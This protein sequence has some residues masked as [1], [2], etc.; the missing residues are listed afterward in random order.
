M[1]DLPPSR[2]YVQTEESRFRSAVSESLAQKIGSSINF[3]NSNQKY[4]KIFVV[5]GQY[6][7]LSLP[8][9]GIDGI[10][11]LPDNAEITNAE[12][13]IRIAGSG[14]DTILDI[15]YATTPGG[16]WTSIFSTLPSINYSSG[17]FSWCY[18]GSS[19]PNT[20]APVLGTT[21]LQAGWALRCDI[22]SAQ[23]GAAKGAGIAVYMRPSN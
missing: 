18:T 23:S 2:K 20:T 14:G 11:V 9:P 1:T 19:F 4:D 22:I 3:I 12:M 17:N 6:N 13:Y 15:K 7:L 5:N 16:S 21:L 8:F 10:F